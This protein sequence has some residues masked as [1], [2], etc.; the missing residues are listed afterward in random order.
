MVT[1]FLEDTDG[2]LE[3]HVPYGDQQLRNAWKSA[4]EALDERPFE[5]YL[6]QSI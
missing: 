6:W 1:K 3:H 5:D 4:I 2:S